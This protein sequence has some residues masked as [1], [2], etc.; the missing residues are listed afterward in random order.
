[1]SQP[2]PAAALNGRQTGRIY[3][4][5]SKCVR[6]GD[7]VQVYATFYDDDDGDIWVFENHESGTMECYTCEAYECEWSEILVNEYQTMES[8]KSIVFE[9][10]SKLG[11][12][13]IEPCFPGGRNGTLNDPPLDSESLVFTTINQ[14]IEL[15]GEIQ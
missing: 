9:Q 11:G 2:S 7:I 12:T 15:D 6:T 4:R 13:S 10:C 1:M 8:Q 3:D 5:C 14:T